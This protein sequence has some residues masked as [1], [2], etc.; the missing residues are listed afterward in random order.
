MHKTFN[1]I[2][3]F[4]TILLWFLM[5]RKAPLSKGVTALLDIILFISL[6]FLVIKYCLM[7]RE[8]R[9]K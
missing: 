6:V 7:L 5:I 8:R 3:Y 1:D 2:F 4:I 9:K